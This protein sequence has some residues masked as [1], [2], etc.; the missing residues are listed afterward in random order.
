MTRETH[1]H[2]LAILL[3]HALQ[4]AD[5]DRG[6]MVA[7]LSIGGDTSTVAQMSS[8]QLVLLARLVNN[9]QM[10]RAGMMTD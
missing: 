6:E 4:E 7:V 2:N 5:G 8:E 9:E 10:R 3:L 1:L